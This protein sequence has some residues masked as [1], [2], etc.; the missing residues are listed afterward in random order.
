MTGKYNRKTH[1]FDK[2]LSE[3]DKLSPGE[4][5][6]IVE[7][8]RSR[9]A[10]DPIADQRRAA[11]REMEVR[12]WETA[13]FG[14]ELDGSLATRGFSHSE[15]PDWVRLAAL[16]ILVRWNE[17][18]PSLR[19]CVHSPDPLS[20]QPISSAAWKPGL[21]VCMKCMHLLMCAPGSREDRTCDHCRKYVPEGEAIF[22]LVTT[23]PPLMY[24]F[25]A[26]RECTD[27]EGFATAGE[28]I[29][30]PTTRKADK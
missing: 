10:G 17:K 8:L 3:F 15:M 2:M 9:D 7:E 1:L 4:K 13:R 11:G 19:T 16:D 26:C 30:P 6:A 22:S 24:Q 25:G 23:I 14:K 20:P 29:A 21:I 12:F 18:D 5:K 27:R 28:E